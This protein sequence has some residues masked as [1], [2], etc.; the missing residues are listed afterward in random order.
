MLYLIHI[1]NFTCHFQMCIFT[2]FFYASIPYF[3]TSAATGQNVEKSV[4]TLLD[5]IMKRME[6]CVE[7]TQVPDTVNGGNSGK[8]DGEK[9]AEKKCAC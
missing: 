8:L 7:K 3:E 5:L 6:Q 9:L 2:Y 4:E 1:H